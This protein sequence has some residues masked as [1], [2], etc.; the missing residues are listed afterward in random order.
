MLRVRVHLPNNQILGM[1]VVVI[2]V[3]LL[4]KYMID[5]VP[6]PL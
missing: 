1:W 2:L 6:G 5:L 3:Q 4:S